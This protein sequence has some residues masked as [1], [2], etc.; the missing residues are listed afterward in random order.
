MMKTVV[1]MAR[2]RRAWQDRKAKIKCVCLSPVP[3]ICFTYEQ[4]IDD[5]KEGKCDCIC[6]RQS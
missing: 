1:E 3:E 2:E 4:D 5:D 6:H